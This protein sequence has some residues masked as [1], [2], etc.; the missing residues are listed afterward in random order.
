M[1]S[2]KTTLAKKGEVKRDWLLI[3]ATDQVL[4]RLATR[5]TNILRGKHKVFFTPHQD[6]GDFVVV[7][8]AA[9]VRLTGE[10]KADKI[11]YRHTGYIGG[12]KEVT[13]GRLLETHPERIIVR[14]VHG[15]LP[16]NRLSRHLLRKLHVYA[17]P[18][19]PHVAQQPRLLEVS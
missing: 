9:K 6:T 7:I 11:Y 13:A 15:M 19:H 2:Q 5:I 1:Q 4:G 10:K 12:I 3:D 8:N 17:G 18:E 16:K 14:A